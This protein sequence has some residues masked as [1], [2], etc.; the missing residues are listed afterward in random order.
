MP[1]RIL[2]PKQRAAVVATLKTIFA[3]DTAEAVRER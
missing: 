1:W 3:H 2:P